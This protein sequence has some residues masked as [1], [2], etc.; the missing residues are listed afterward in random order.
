M[1]NA[2]LSIDYDT[3]YQA[4]VVTNPDKTEVRFETG[5]AVADYQSAISYARTLVD[6]GRA[7]YV[8]TS[9]SLND[10]VFDVDGYRFDEND[11]LQI[12]LRRWNE[13]DELIIDEHGNIMEE[14]V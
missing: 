2:F 1:S 9:S 4:V 13:R 5:D 12:D 7:I 14:P 11:M 3:D 10:F 8:L 6:A